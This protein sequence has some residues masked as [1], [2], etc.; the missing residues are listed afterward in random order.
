MG[1]WVEI[2]IGRIVTVKQINIFISSG[3]DSPKDYKIFGTNNH[4]SWNEL[5]GITN[6]PSESTLYNYSVNPSSG[7]RYYRIVINKVQSGTSFG[8]KIKYVQY[9]GIP[10][11]NNFTHTNY[12]IRY[13]KKQ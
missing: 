9:L 8:D 7:Y 12:T 2:D 3:N 6:R 10:E 4:S 1:P 5:L 11:D 13:N